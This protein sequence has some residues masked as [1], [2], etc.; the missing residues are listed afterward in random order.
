MARASV[1]TSSTG[2]DA[3]GC[4]YATSAA[5]GPPRLPLTLFGVERH[6]AQRGPAW[7]YLFVPVL[8]GLVGEPSATCRAQACALIVADGPQ[9]QREHDGVPQPRLEVDQVAFEPADLFVVRLV[10]WIG[11]ELADLGLDRCGDRVEAARALPGHRGTGLPGDE[12]ALH[13]RLEAQAEL[14]RAA[15]GH[16]DEVQL[17]P[18]RSGHGP[19]DDAHRT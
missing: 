11:V 16:A 19:L 15:F 1:R 13:D 17:E 7:V 18:G 12:D 14:D 9:W 2:N 8:V 6:Q 5:S 10:P 4:C 3:N